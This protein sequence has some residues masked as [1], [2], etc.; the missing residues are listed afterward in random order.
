M[1]I[2]VKTQRGFL[3]P[4]YSL[5]DQSLVHKYDLICTVKPEDTLKSI[6][7]KVQNAEGP[8]STA[9]ASQWWFN[10]TILNWTYGETISSHNI[11]DGSVI[12]VIHRIY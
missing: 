7:E 4:D 10:N 11:T 9:T 2:T 1:N 12:K 3:E 6:V 5:P 8:Q